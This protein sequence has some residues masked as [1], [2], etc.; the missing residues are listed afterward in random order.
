[1]E[2]RIVDDLLVKQVI[3]AIM[4]HAGK[5]DAVYRNFHYQSVE[6]GVVCEH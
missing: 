6:K 1:L 3:A 2:H 5:A 4:A